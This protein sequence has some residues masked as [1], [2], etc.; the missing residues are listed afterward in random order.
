LATSIET[1]S[2]I[3]RDAIRDAI[4]KYSLW[5]LIEGFLLA[6]A[7]VLAIIFPF[8]FSVAAVVMLGWLLVIT[9]IF[10]IIGLLGARHSPNFWLHLTSVVLSIWIGVLLLRNPGDGLLVLTLMLLVYLMIQGVSRVAFALTIRPIANWF[11]VLASGVLGIAMACILWAS[12]PLTAVWLIGVLLGIELL[13][14][15]LS[16]VILAW[17]IRRKIAA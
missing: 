3:Y 1:A 10:R 16:T 2:Q 12:M 11:W 6:A 15:G 13:G 8:I 7:G 9:G 4:R 17:A 14:V 5:F